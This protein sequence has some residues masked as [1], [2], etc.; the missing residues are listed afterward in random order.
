MLALNMWV[1]FP[2]CHLHLGNLF[3]EVSEYT[4]EVQC[5]RYQR[6]VPSRWFSE[7]EVANLLIEQPVCCV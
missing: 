1:F 2:L 3:A 5:Q 7:E 6:G 4:V